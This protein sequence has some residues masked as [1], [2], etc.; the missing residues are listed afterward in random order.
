MCPDINNEMQ[1]I[2][3]TDID[4]S[5]AFFVIPCRVSWSDHHFQ[6][7]YEVSG[8][9]TPILQFAVE[10]CL[11]HVKSDIVSKLFRYMGWRRPGGMDQ[12]LGMLMEAFGDEWGLSLLDR[13]RIF[14][15]CHKL[16]ASLLREAEKLA[17]KRLEENYDGYFMRACHDDNSANIR[18]STTLKDPKLQLVTVLYHRTSFF[19]L[20]AYLIS[21]KRPLGVPEVLGCPYATCNGS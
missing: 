20:A 5:A 8:A 19:N 10:R 21:F 17:D 1:R 16:S 7:V 13:S 3:T 11:A 14:S 12:I 9:A 4:T 6:V 18:L 2:M 15:K